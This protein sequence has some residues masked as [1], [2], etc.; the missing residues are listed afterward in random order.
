VSESSSNEAKERAVAR[1][2]ERIASESATLPYRWGYIQGGLLIPWSLLGII[3]TYLDFRKPG[4]EPSY[5]MAIE[6]VMCLLGLPLGYGLLQKKSFALQL[7]Y[8]MFGL[9]LLLVVLK[10]PV[11]IMHYTESGDTGSAFFEAEL[12]LIWVISIVYYRRRRAQFR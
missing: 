4:H 3:S 12:L 7:V 1:M 8:V 11:A 5:L 2:S 6:L 10:L 9:S